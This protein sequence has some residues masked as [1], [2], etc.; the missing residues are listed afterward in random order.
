MYIVSVLVI[1]MHIKQVMP[2]FVLPSEL[3][4]D[5]DKVGDRKQEEA[6][7]NDN[8]NFGQI[9]LSQRFISSAREL[10]NKEKR[11]NTKN[12][13]LK[14][15][16]EERYHMKI[17][18]EDTGKT[19]GDNVGY[20]AMDNEVID[21]N[22]E[23][24][25]P[26][27]LLDHYGS[28]SLVSKHK[29]P[30][31]CI[32]TSPVQMLCNHGDFIYKLLLPNADLTEDD[33]GNLVETVYKEIEVRNRGTFLKRLHKRDTDKIENVNDTIGAVTLFANESP[34]NILRF[35][36]PDIEQDE[37]LINRSLLENYLKP[38]AVNSDNYMS[39]VEYNN[40][41]NE[42]DL[43][44]R[45]GPPSELLFEI[46]RP[47]SYSCRWLSKR[48]IP[49]DISKTQRRLPTRKSH[50][51]RRRLSV[52]EGQAGSSRITKKPRLSQPIQVNIPSQNTVRK[53][54]AGSRSKTNRIT[55]KPKHKTMSLS[56]SVL[57]N[58][59]YRT[60]SPLPALRTKYTRFKS[61]PSYTK[62][63]PLENNNKLVIKKKSE[64][65]MKLKD[66][67]KPTNKKKYNKE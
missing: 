30:V 31:Q 48:H 21:L 42:E 8:P 26:H 29:K 6:L 50:K 35:T 7:L 44:S 64:N 16:V 61:T 4:E 51:S 28:N 65:P 17:K 53:F 23:N 32:K 3:R 15:V 43:R 67:K 66:K 27:S 49:A 63:I 5:E 25:E 45:K 12:N 40:A 60:N 55:K 2:I 24:D 46:N 1:L 34:E 38:E 52:N 47:R 19:K 54:S 10:F 62:V 56:P 36:L 59:Q 41:S 11:L 37:V 57:A 13:D 39:Q 20:Y 33:L 9:L 14:R 22:S 18:N 58:R